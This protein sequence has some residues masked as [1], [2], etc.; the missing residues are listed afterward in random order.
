LGSVVVTSRVDIAGV[1][2][3]AVAVA[4][5]AHSPCPVLSL[6]VLER[7]FHIVLSRLS[8]QY[9][10]PREACL[11]VGLPSK[12]D[13]PENRSISAITLQPPSIT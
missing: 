2:S 4:G 6:L 7:P 3:L 11:L 9:F 8:A 12:S 1:H 10:T 13:T 5:G